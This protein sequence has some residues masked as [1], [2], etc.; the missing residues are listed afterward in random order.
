[1]KKHNVLGKIED[2]VPKSRIMLKNDIFISLRKQSTSPSYFYIYVAK[3]MKFFC[4]CCLR[5]Y[6]LM[7]N[8]GIA[9]DGILWL[10][11]A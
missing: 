1:M 3:N 5:F 7:L 4:S 8:V 9:V 2:F 10:V 6:A 11:H